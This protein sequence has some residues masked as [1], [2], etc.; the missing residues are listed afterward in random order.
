M[1]MAA[2]GN[3]VF[4]ANS[5]AIEIRGY[6]QGTTVLHNKI[7]GRARAALAVVTQGGGIP[8]NSEF[9]S[10]DLEGFQATLTGVLVDKGVT[11]TRLVGEKEKFED[12]GIGTVIVRLGGKEK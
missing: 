3:A 9:V 5:A 8:G 10:N 12:G 4:G 1:T 11:N 6:A 7:R 2:P